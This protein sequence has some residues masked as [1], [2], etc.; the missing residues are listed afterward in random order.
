MDRMWSTNISNVSPMT[1]W[2]SNN[3]TCI[4]FIGIKYL[5][6]TA[7][8]FRLQWFDESTTTDTY[9]ASHKSLLT[10]RNA[11]GASAFTT[12]LSHF[13]LAH[14]NLFENSFHMMVDVQSTNLHEWLCLTLRKASNPS[15]AVRRF[16]SP[17][18]SCC[19]VMK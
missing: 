14:V 7:T 11:K 1:F 16:Y 15:S 19:L 18:S 6:K 17:F 3:F 2:D 12:I 4:T 8:D 10:S 5:T 9:F 13:V